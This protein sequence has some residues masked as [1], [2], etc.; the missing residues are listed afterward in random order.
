MC[1]ENDDDLSVFF[2]FFID[3]GYMSSANDL[4]VLCKM[5]V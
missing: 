1:V 5:S 4:T 3:N 2:F